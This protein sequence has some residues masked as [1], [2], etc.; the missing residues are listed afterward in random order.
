MYIVR[1]GFA[2]DYLDTHHQLQNTGQEFDGS[3]SGARPDEAVSW[4]KIRAGAE[5]VKVGT[6]IPRPRAGID[7]SA[8]LCRCDARFP[9]ASCGDVRSSSNPRLGI[10]GTRV[11]VY[12][13]LVLEPKDP[14]TQS[15]STRCTLPRAGDVITKHRQFVRA[16][17]SSGLR[18]RHDATLM[19]LD[20]IFRAAA[21]LVGKS[22]TANH[23]NESLQS[24]LSARITKYFTE[25]GV[26]EVNYDKS[27]L[28]AVQ[29]QTAKEALFVVR[30]VHSALTPAEA[31]QSGNATAEA[32]TAFGTRDVSHL[33]TLISIVFKWGTDALLDRLVL[34]WTT[35]ASSTVQGSTSVVGPTRG[36]EDYK[37]LCDLTYQLLSLVLPSGHRGQLSQSFV[38]N[39]VLTRHLNDLLKPCIIVG[40]LPKT[41]STP[42]VPVQDDIR[43]LTMRL[44]S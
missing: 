13:I 20:P 34:N 12:R 23:A 15:K 16:I 25:R 31:N 30:Q 24:V 35:H 19:A 22:T 38:A 36:Q 39:L 2:R 18:F 37:E 44:L 40:W 27:D 8:G 28:S 32:E 1:S 4:G 33:R 9:V 42:S 26:P 41:L 29:L 10:V 11:R 7:P 43:P 6:F 3:D 21:H 5:S 17:R 14:Q